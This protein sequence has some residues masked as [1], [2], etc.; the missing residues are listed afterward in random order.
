VL[1]RHGVEFRE[2]R[3]PQLT[4][5]RR[6]HL[7]IHNPPA[8]FFRACPGSHPV[9]QLIHRVDIGQRLIDLTRRSVGRVSVVFNKPRNDGLPFKVNNFCL[10]IAMR[11]N[12]GYCSNTHDPLTAN[13]QGFSDLK[14]FINGQHLSIHQQKVSCIAFFR[15]QIHLRLLYWLLMTGRLLIWITL[16]IFYIKHVL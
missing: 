14:A 13:G 1:R 5:A 7:R 6:K 4:Q 15:G 3:L 9:E 10:R 12:F 16:L 2:R 8:W 11:P